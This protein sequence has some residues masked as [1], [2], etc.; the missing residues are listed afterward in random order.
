MSLLASICL[1]APAANLPQEPSVPEAA[2]A[3]A[4]V[5]AVDL[6]YRGQRKW[7]IRLP[8]EEWKPVG[9]AFALKAT[10]GF[11]FKTEL[12]G[13]RLLVDT[14]GDGQTDVSVTGTTGFVT[15]RGKS[16]AGQ[17]ISYAVRLVNDKGWKFAPGGFLD[18]SIKGTRIRLID[19]NNNGVF[20]D[21]GKDAMIVGA[22]R[23]ASYFSEVV[24]V[25][26][27]LF[28][29]AVAEDGTQ[30]SCAPYVGAT[31][32]LHLACT[33]KGK[34]MAAVIRSADRKFSYD[35][36]QATD[37]MMV[38]VA[39]YQLITG[40]LGLGASRVTMTTGKSKAIAVGKNQTKQVCWG[41]PVQAEFAYQRG[42]GQV[43]LSPDQVWLYGAAGELY[44]GWNPLGAS[45]K[46][47]ITEDSTGK[48]VAQAHFP[49]TC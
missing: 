45:P 21:V 9:T 29:V 4:S 17:P 3:T 41:G 8:A 37:G 18:G 35:M 47:T 11:D 39:A 33:T 30:L 6:N 24:N 16:G 20:G 25:G 1:I 36:A 2:P 22:S 32:T 13:T 31:G 27:A 28:T 46:F 34:V 19:Q 40:E 5:F 48:E 42:G 7:K 10:H 15:L 44:T 38:P 49:G 14:D 43:K 12:A 26:G 23:I